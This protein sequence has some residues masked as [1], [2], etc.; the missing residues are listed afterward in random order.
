M[1]RSS[2]D[3][4]EPAGPSSAVSE[5]S[6]IS[7]ETSSSADEVAEALGDVAD[8]D[9]ASSFR[10]LILVIASSVP[11]AIRASRAEAA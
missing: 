8:G 9:H 1:M 10:G 4:P 5:P 2:V 7:S 6:G 11:S 3:L